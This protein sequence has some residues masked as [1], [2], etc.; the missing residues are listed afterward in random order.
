MNAL[1]LILTP[2]GALILAPYYAWS[3][4]FTLYEWGWFAFFMVAT[5]MSITAGYHRL[6][7]HKSYKAH[8]LIRVFYAVW[9]ACSCQN[10]ILKWSSDHRSHHRFVDD[11]VKD[12]YAAS[13]GFWYSHIGWVFRDYPRQVA[14]FENVKD[15]MRDPVVRWQHKYYI[16][17]VILTNAGIPLLLGWMHGRL[18]GTLILAFFL[19]VTLNHHFTFF[20]NSLA[21]YWGRRPYSDANSSRDNALLAYVCY[22]EGYHNYHHT[23][24][25]DYRNG[26]R[27]W[28]FD[29]S[30]WVIRMFSWLGLTHDLK[31]ANRVQI[32]TARVMMELKN[33]MIKVESGGEAA[34][35]QGYLEQTHQQ[36]VAA[37]E[38]WARVKK[39]WRQ[40]RAS[41]G[42]RI[43]R[44]ELRNRFLELKYQIKS[45]RRQW[46]LLLADLAAV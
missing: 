20:I 35:F 19:R 5:G 40:K 26:I 3:F 2:L 46:R 25:H 27:W 16:P 23:F 36:F 10:S 31:R 15:L 18:F 41:L 22:G 13:N 43:E 24:Q 34:R 6:W 42:A 12:P 1:F 21:H 28:H 38:E 30:K 14:N 4:G 7:S 45:N 44:I 11:G 39:Q 29:P 9:G 17:L 32:E 8:F 33:A 37:L